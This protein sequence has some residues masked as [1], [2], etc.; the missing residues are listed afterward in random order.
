MS[1]LSPAQLVWIGFALL[2]AGVV[3]PFLM[4]IRVLESTLLLNFVAYIASV[5]GLLIG[6]IGLLIHTRARRREKDPYE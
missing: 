4:V 3:L 1:R 5:S 6:M 2:V